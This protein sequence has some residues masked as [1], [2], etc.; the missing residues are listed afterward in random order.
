M[1]LQA[2]KSQTI[3]KK[4]NLVLMKGADRLTG[5]DLVR[6]TKVAEEAGATLYISVPS[7]QVFLGVPVTQ[8]QQVLIKLRE[9]GYDSVR[10]TRK[11]DHGFPLQLSEDRSG[12]SLQIGRSENF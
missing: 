1:M 8:Q 3:F 4:V 9:R 6:I 7:W 10:V 2:R 12:A 5:D 11:V